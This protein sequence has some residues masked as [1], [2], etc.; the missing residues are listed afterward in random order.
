[1]KFINGL[2]HNQQKKSFLHRNVTM[3]FLT[4]EPNLDSIR[5]YVDEADR[6]YSN[7]EKWLRDNWKAVNKT[8][9]LVIY[10]NLYNKLS[11]AKSKLI[12]ALPRCD[13][14]FNS[15]VKISERVDNYIYLCSRD[16]DAL[17]QRSSKTEL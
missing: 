12:E 6:F 10:E 4:C 9:R 16:D 8:T 13:K 2:K 14:F 3:R 1:M 15:P 5:G 11:T 7:E 17:R